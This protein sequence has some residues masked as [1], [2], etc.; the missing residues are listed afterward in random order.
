MP[1]RK[2]PPEIVDAVNFNLA[3]KPYQKIILKNGVGVYAVD[4]GAEEVMSVEWVF[5][6]GNC[7]EEQ[8]LVA[9]TANFLLRNGTS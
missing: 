4:A 1:D 9:A 8:N 7:F 2:Q 6:A 5:N 3:L